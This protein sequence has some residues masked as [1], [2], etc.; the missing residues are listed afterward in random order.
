[1]RLVACLL[2]GACAGFP[3]AQDPQQLFADAVQAQQRGDDATAISRYR[4]L[5]KIRPDVIEAR[6][7]LGAA[8]ARLGRIDEALQEYRAVLQRDPNNAALRLNLALAYYKKNDFASAAKELETT[9]AAGPA[10]LQAALLL[11]DCYT[12]LGR[13]A[14]VVRLLGPLEKTNPDELGIAWLLGSAMI[15]TGRPQNGLDR[16][17]KAARRGN[18]AEA[19]LLA[20]RTA[21]GLNEF[22]RARD[23]AAA[24]AQLNPKLPGVFTLLGTAK[25]YYGDNKGAIADLTKAIEADPNDFDAHLALGAVLYTERDMERAAKHLS[26]ALEMNPASNVARFQMARLQRT[27]GDLENARKNLEQVVRESPDWAQ[28]HMELSAVYFR[29]KRREDGE[30]ERAIFDRLNNEQQAREREA[31][32]RRTANPATVAPSR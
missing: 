4:E 25:Q 20:A 26:R 22:E 23:D 5:L 17:E 6:A 18:N 10:N 7:N 11:A 13:Y 19:Y 12:R 2:L 29:L 16:V 32:K 9:R 21:L 3:Q 28:P 14:D 1:M 31:Q 8:L 15:R 27:E 30:R 24:A